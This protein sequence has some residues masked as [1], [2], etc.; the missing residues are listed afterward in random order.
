MRSADYLIF[1]KGT[2]LAVEPSKC[3]SLSPFSLHLF[4]ALHSFFLSKEREIKEL[5]LP[6]LFWG[7]K[8]VQRERFYIYIKNPVFI[9]TVNTVFFLALEKNALQAEWKAGPLINIAGWKCLT[10]FLKN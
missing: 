4:P 3:S 6:W 7:Y 8:E 5:F 10:N 2:T 1:G 9:P